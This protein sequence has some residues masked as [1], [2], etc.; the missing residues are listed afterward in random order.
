MSSYLGAGPSATSSEEI[1]SLRIQPA[2]LLLRSA[3]NVVGKDE[4]LKSFPLQRNGRMRQNLEPVFQAL[5]KMYYP[6]KQDKLS[7]SA[8]V[9]HSMLMW[10]TLK[11]SLISMEIAARCGRTHITPNYGIN[12]MYEEL[13]S[14]SGFIMWLL[15]KVVQNWQTKNGVHVLQR[16]RGTQLF[17]A[18]ICSGISLDYTSGTSGQGTI[19]LLLWP[20]HL[21]SYYC[22]CYN[23]NYM[24]KSPPPISVNILYNWHI[25]GIKI[26]VEFKP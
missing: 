21:I 11:Y 14:S 12:A 22:L 13:K 10:D 1:S 18:S 24:I 2:L 26:E 7:R 4:T 16:Y 20:S 5:F 15:L 25:N 23:A 8:R 17:A 3:A 9:S 19:L 6:N